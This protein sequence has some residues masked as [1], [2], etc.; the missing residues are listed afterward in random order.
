[1]PVPSKRDRRTTF[2]P[3]PGLAFCP[4]LPSWLAEFGSAGTCPCRCTHWPI[5][6]Q[7]SM[8]HA[9]PSAVMESLRRQPC[10]PAT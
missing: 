1:M 6:V 4:R 3:F 10:N 5:S 8:H 9:T 2:R 7:F